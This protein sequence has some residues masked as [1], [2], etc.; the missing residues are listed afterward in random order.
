LFQVK[1]LTQKIALKSVCYFHSH[2]RVGA[3]FAG[4]V[5]ETHPMRIVRARIGGFVL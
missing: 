5:L 4:A 2:K 3:K 1:G